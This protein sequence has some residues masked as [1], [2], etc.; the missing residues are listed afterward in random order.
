MKQAVLLTLAAALPLIASAQEKPY[1]VTGKIGKANAKVYLDIRKKSGNTVDSAVVKDGVF[2]FKGNVE[3]PTLVVLSMDHAGTGKPQGPSDARRIY[4]EPGNIKIVGKDSVKTADIVS[5]INTEF[6]KYKATFAAQTAGI[7][8]IN[9]DYM[10]APDDKKKDEAFQNSLGERYEKIAKEKEAI[11]NTYIDQ[12]PNS[13]FSLVALQEISSGDFNVATIEPRFNKLSD[14][15][16]TSTA[17]KNFKEVIEKEKAVAM[18]AVAPNFTQNDVNDKPVSLTDFRGKYVLID[19][20]ASW[21]GP[22]RREN[23]NVVKAFNAYKD[24]NF[25][26]LGVSLDQPNAKDKW[27]AAIEKD[28]LTWTQVSDLKFWNNA[29]A[30]LYN[31]KGIPANF[32]LD[33][34]GKIVGKNLRGED[35]EKKLAELLH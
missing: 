33:P 9:A 29:A 26:I 14:K 17:G 25:T 35:L 27:L 31:V 23:P 3:G 11:Q 20:W 21:C 8:Q 30:E 5:P 7:D 6:A 34:S 4:L 15:L 19:F 24:K 22:C 18:G 16:K 28:N 1:T 2:T 32:L 10:A 12:N 13:Y